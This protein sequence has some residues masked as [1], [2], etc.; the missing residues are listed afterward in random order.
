MATV[1]DIMTPNPTCCTPRSSMLE[2]AR[3]MRDHDCGIVPIVEDE[4]TMRLV[5]V[6]TDRDIVVRLIAEGRNPLE[7]SVSDCITRGVHTLHPN[8]SLRDC[9]QLMEG[10]HVR[11]IPIVDGSDRLIGIVAMADLAEEIED[12]KLGKTLAEVSEPD[13]RQLYSEVHEDTSTG[14]TITSDTDPVNEHSVA[15]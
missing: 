9:R 6:I 10:Q 2:A 1:A 12:D 7:S 13:N 11:R 8:D 5:G 4:T 15:T 3:I 14:N